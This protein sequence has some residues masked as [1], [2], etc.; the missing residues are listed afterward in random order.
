MAMMAQYRTLLALGSG[1]ILL[2]SSCGSP[3]EI[4]GTGTTADTLSTAN[5]TGILSIGGRLFSIPSPVQAALA[6]RTSGLPYRKELTTPL[7]RIDGATGKLGQ[8]TLLGIYGADLAYVTVH[9]DGQRAMETLQ[10]IEKLAGRLELSNAFDR[11]LMEEFRTN[12]SNEDSL[13]RFSGKAFGAADKYLRTNQRE[14]VSTLVLVGGWLQSMHL[15][16][17]DPNAL[18]DQKL[19]D[20]MGDQKA[21]LNALIELLANTD[22][23]RS[24][25][26]LLNG[27]R[28]LRNEFDGITR[29]Y[30]YQSPVTDAARRITF[31]NSTSSVA[32][33]E[34]RLDAI[35]TRVEAVR[36]MIIA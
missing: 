33:P 31:I 10:A 11:R 24:A 36:N 27:M 14:D 12:L 4:G 5:G 34:G 25:Q 35:R 21:T 26:P 3:Q 22:M 28:E 2:V 7:D 30:A 15:T 1:F 8:A 17:A 16:L 32:I 18:K 20:R 13:L 29:S 19:M 23:D 6:I 9:Q